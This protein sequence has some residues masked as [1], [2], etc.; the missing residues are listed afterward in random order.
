MARRSPLRT[1]V[2]RLVRGLAAALSIGVGLQASA[3][4]LPREG[5]DY[6]VVQPAQPTSAPAGRVEVVEFF[7]YW[8]PACNGFEPTLHDW[9]ARNASSVRMVYVPIPTHFRAGQAD[10][11][12][13]YYALDA[14]GSE[15]ALRPKI[16]AALHV[17]H[18]LTDTADANALA[19]WVATQGI[20][21]E[22][23]KATFDSFAVQSKVARADQ[24][25]K[26]YGLTGTP[27][28]AIG[29]RYLV[30]VDARRLPV[31]DQLLVRALA[32]R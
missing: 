13:L 20:D 4:G 22:K 24:M 29:G 6:T 27:S 28:L 32:E 17:Q 18:T 21:R 14:L 11:Q 8:C 1:H 16:F 30:Q 23:F 3:Q 5:V 10:L 31:V 15:P 25:A 12:K 7:G 2:G 9:A 26:A 19:D